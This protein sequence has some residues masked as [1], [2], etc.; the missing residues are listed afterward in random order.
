[1]RRIGFIWLLSFLS[2][3]VPM[4]LWYAFDVFVLDQCDP[5]FGCAGTFRL[6]LFI[7]GTA[8]LLAA[9]AML[10]SVVYLLKKHGYELDKRMLLGLTGVGI[11]LSVL[12]WA[13][14]QSTF[15]ELPGLL[16]GWFVIALLLSLAALSVSMKITKRS[17][18]DDNDRHVA[19]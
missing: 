5:K 10:S 6:L 17:A 19:G 8:A 4:N 7:H 13:F 1:M 2:V 15:W 11:V 18:A 14:L 16:V 3:L 12:S 9:F